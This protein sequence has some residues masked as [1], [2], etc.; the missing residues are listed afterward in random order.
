M[1]IA[2]THI[3]PVPYI[4]IIK[5]VY[6]SGICECLHCIAMHDNLDIAFIH[7]Y[8]YMSLGAPYRS[9]RLYTGI[10]HCVAPTSNSYIH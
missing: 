4:T 10:L 2:A 1:Y 6:V 8:L 9:Y 3:T 5:S 7:G